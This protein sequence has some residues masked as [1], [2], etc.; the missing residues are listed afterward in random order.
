MNK[1]FHKEESSKTKQLLKHNYN[2]LQRLIRPT[3][4]RK[5]TPQTYKPL[6]GKQSL[7]ANITQAY[8]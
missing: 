4:T 7:D 5:T 2:P 1:K 8:Y 6:H 3:K